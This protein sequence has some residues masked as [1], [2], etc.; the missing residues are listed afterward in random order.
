MSSRAQELLRRVDDMQASVRTLAKTGSGDET[1]TPVLLLSRAG[2]AYSAAPAPRTYLSVQSLIY[3]CLVPACSSLDAKLAPNA[4]PPPHAMHSVANFPQPDPFRPRMQWRRR[5]DP[6]AE[7]ARQGPKPQPRA[8]AAP[9]PPPIATAAERQR[10]EDELL[11]LQTPALP[12]YS[13]GLL[14]GGGP[15]ASQP[16]T[17]RTLSLAT[18]PETADLK[19]ASS[20]FLEQIQSTRL[21]QREPASGGVATGAESET[22]ARETLQARTEGEAARAELART[23]QDLEHAR[24]EL[25]DVQQCDP[26]SSIVLPAAVRGVR[27]GECAFCAAGRR[28][29]SATRCSTRR[30]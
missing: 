23:Q 4:H 21:A 18:Q 2:W 9:S 5:D 15:R 8:K 22:L 19:A 14:S 13:A 1:A 30:G 11:H 10:S 12:L 27:R 16:G 3:N 17:P 25:R 7:H 24:R 20:R 6:L 26:L 29:S 28:R